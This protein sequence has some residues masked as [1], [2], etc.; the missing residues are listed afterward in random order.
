VRWA[1]RLGDVG[2]DIGPEIEVAPDGIT[3]LTGTFRNAAGTPRGFIAKVS[4]KGRVLW[5]AES[6]NSPFAT[7]GEISLGPHSVNVLGR[8]VSTVTL[9]S[10]KLTG[11]GATDFFLARLPR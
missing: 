10:F 5:T 7:L 8:Y 6:T 1:T 9:G 2:A 11:P 4:R 3:F